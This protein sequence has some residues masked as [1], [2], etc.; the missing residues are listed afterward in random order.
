[1]VQNTSHIFLFFYFLRRE[2]VFV[3]K[4]NIKN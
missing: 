4:I 3:N 1:M 2:S